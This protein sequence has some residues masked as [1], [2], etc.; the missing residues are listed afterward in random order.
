MTKET[1]LLWSAASTADDKL[2]VPFVAPS[3]P[4]HFLVLDRDVLE[5]GTA[6][7]GM[8]LDK[9][10]ERFRMAIERAAAGAF[11]EHRFRELVNVGTG[12]SI[13]QLWLTREDFDR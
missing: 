4:R 5:D 7:V 8:P 6:A 10:V 3:P 12:E 1:V 9:M 13:F 2:V 11:P